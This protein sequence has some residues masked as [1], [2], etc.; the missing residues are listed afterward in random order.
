[1]CALPDLTGAHSSDDGLGNA[2]KVHHIVVDCGG[3]TAQ[4]RRILVNMPLFLP[5]MHDAVKAIIRGGAELQGMQ[6]PNPFHTLDFCSQVD[7]ED[8]FFSF[9]H[10]FNFD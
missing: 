6:L 5:N 9:K 1:M 7:I 2:N 10:L 3:T 4:R 8:T